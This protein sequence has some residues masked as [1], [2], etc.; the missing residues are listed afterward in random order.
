MLLTIMFH[1]HVRLNQRN[2]DKAD[3]ITRKIKIKIRGEIAVS[4]ILKK[5]RELPKKSKF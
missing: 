4:V 5:T 1:F 2:M 3:Q